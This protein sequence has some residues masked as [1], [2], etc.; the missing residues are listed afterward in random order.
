MLNSKSVD[1]TTDI[2]LIVKTKLGGLKRRNTNLNIADHQDWD[3]VHE[4]TDDP[5]ACGVENASK[6]R[7]FSELTAFVQLTC[8]NLQHD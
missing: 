7:Q 3:T 5:P 4:Y 1:H 6:F 8:V 2:K